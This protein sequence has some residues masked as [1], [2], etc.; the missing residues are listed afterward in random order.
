MKGLSWSTAYWI[1]EE[2]DTP[3]SITA[4]FIV[5]YAL[6]NPVSSLTSTMRLF[7]QER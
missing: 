4:S 2:L 5:S 1:A 3:Q 7:V 6:Q